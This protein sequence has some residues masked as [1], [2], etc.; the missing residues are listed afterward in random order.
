MSGCRCPRC[1]YRWRRDAGRPLNQRG[2]AFI[3]H[4]PGGANVLGG[5]MTGAQAP[6][7]RLSWLVVASAARGQGV[8]QALAN[9]AGRRP[10]TRASSSDT[11]HGEQGHGQQPGRLHHPPGRVDHVCHDHHAV[12]M[13]LGI[14][15]RT[16]LRRPR[17]LR[18]LVRQRLP[19]QIRLHGRA[20]A[21]LGLRP[22]PLRRDAPTS[23]PGDL[24]RRRCP[25]TAD[26][27][28]DYSAA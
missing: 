11:P 26:L 22:E 18:R 28:V 23:R 5:L 14:P 20:L 27:D 1:R 25:S 9:H 7:Y 13:V 17:P 12:A 6:T 19:E 3:A 15:R 10:P 16:P 21:A 2:S 8:G 24:H 4:A